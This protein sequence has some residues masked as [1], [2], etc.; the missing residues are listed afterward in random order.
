MKQNIGQKAASIVK[1]T[2][3][4]RIN[5]EKAAERFN[6]IIEELLEDH[7]LTPVQRVKIESINAI[8][9][10]LYKTNSF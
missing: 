9:N 4:V 8:F 10:V 1:D 7:N 6:R 3:A 2:N 5:K